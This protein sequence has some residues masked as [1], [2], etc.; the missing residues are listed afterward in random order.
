MLIRN[1]ES[2]FKN[3]IF[4]ILL[5]RLSRI[6]NAHALVVKFSQEQKTLYENKKY[7]PDHLSLS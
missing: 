3:I 6:P 7:I 5:L 2:L 1:F 4:I